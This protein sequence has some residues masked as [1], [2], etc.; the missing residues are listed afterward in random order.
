MPVLKTGGLSNEAF[1]IS[2]IKCQVLI[3]ETS[4]LA[5]QNLTRAVR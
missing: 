1:S 3:L 5:R 4:N 2:T